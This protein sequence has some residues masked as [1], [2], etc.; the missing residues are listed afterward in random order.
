MEIRNIDQDIHVR[1]VKADSFP[2]GVKD[3]HRKLHSLVPFDGS[4]RYFGISNPD[5]SG[6]IVY[7]AAAEEHAKGELSSTGLDEFTLR[8]GQY[9]CI[10]IRDYMNDLS[11]IG[12]A[13][14]EMLPDPRIDPKGY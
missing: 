8:K 10:E 5:K 3:A 6:S 14:K 4:R 2:N 13:F 11:S 7:K 9:L 12:R 1:L